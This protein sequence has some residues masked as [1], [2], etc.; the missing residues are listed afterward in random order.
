MQF[1]GLQRQGQSVI[2]IGK[3]PTRHDDGHSCTY[4]SAPWP[5]AVPRHLVNIQV[6]AMQKQRTYG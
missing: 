3:I 6:E 2:E 4:A 5:L 1:R